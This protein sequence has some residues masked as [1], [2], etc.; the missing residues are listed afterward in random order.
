MTMAKSV[1][2][3]K[4]SCDVKLKKFLKRKATGAANWNEVAWF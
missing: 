2:N 4:K 3:Y 1:T